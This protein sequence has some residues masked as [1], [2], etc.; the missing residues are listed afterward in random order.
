MAY[1]RELADRLREQ[2]SDQRLSEKAMFGGLA[3]L[4]NGH[5]A[6][7]ASGG[8]GLLVRC[9]PDETDAHLAA[10]HVGRFV[11][12]GR[13]MDGWLRVDAE[14][15]ADDAELARWAGVGTAYAG[16]LPPK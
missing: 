13:P 9:A 10:P 8:G 6:I 15:V 14:A 16:S 12:R 3:F 1:D 4:V 2:L 11:M 5:M 7:A